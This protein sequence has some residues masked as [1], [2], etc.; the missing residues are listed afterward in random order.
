MVDEDT[1]LNGSECLGGMCELPAIVDR[2]DQAWPDPE[3]SLRDDIANKRVGAASAAI[4]F[5]LAFNRG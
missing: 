3:L 1:V 4:E 5:K 2:S